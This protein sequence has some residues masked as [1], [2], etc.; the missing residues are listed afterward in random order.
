MTAM[1]VVWGTTGLASADADV[2]GACDLV[3]RGEFREALSVLARAEAGSDLDRD[4][5][6]RLI[7]C[8]ALARFATRDM[9]SLEQDI[10]RLVSLEPGHTL[11]DDFGPEVHAMLERVR[12]RGVSALSVTVDVERGDGRVR[13]VA[14]V[15][16]DQGDLVRELRVRA[17]VGRG[18]WRTARDE[19]EVTAGDDA[20]VSYEAVAIGPG[21]AE[22]ERTSGTAAREGGARP[23][24][25]RRRRHPTEER[26]TDG[27]AAWPWVLAGVGAALV[28][29][30][31]VAIVVTAGGNDSTQP[32]APVVA[33]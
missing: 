31:T 21:H 19:V 25:P 30:V 33:W 23:V 10:V 8:R 15:D 1:A 18:P 6:V 24:G 4:A 13:V 16:G 7:E 14:R 11:S 12:A 20:T 26:P 27:T 32:S 28:L 5:L 9:T 17:R 22:I 3:N 29:G 2:E